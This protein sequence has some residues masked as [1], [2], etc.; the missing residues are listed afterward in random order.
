MKDKL[1]SIAFITSKLSVEIA[2]FTGGTF[3]LLT[4]RCP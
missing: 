4:R 1:E 3:V 2:V